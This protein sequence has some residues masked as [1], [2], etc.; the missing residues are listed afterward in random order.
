MIL[1]DIVALIIGTYCLY[2]SIRKIFI[3]RFSFLHISVI[4]FYFLQI[5]PIFVSFFGNMSK[6]EYY[7]KY[8]YLALTDPLVNII[9]DIFLIL[10]VSLLIFFANKSNI[11]MKNKGSMSI[12]LK[13]HQK[14]HYFLIII[15]QFLSFFPIILAILFSPNPNIYLKF[16]YFNTH[17]VSSINNSYLFHQSIVKPCCLISFFSVIILYF[18][19]RK[20]KLMLIFPVILQAWVN[21]KRTIFIFTLLSFLIIDFIKFKKFNFNKKQ[22]RL[23]L[24]KSIVFFV[25]IITYYLVYNKITGKSNFANP[26]LLYTVYFSRMCN[27]KIA[28]YDLVYT[29]SMISYPFQNII[30]DLLFF[31][32]RKFWNSK[33]YGY[34]PYF[35]SYV[36]YGNGGNFI[37]GYGFQVNIWSEFITNG[38]L[39]GYV[40]SLV[41]V[42]GIL[43]YCD[44]ASDLFI[45]LLGS[46]FVFLYMSYGFEN[47]VQ[48]VY[49]FFVL[50]FIINKLKKR[51]HIV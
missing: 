22:F 29:K 12:S 5:F 25:I 4:I 7:Y 28:I 26:Y 8:M 40:M 21:G 9:Y 42:I 51:F 34:Y 3:G 46:A 49:C 35:T 17:L 2:V 30:Y 39:L 41:L 27:V 11:N 15:L 47:I 50:L 38:N 23:F 19:K 13:M 44:T 45:S 20:N 18:I 1:F 36:F 48:I 14:T 32:P 10:T 24:L 6:I 43:K 31:I 37:S 16:S 33:P